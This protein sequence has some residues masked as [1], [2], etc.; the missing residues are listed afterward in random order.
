[1]AH[2]ISNVFTPSQISE[3]ASPSIGSSLQ[4]AEGSYPICSVPQLRHHIPTV[5]H[6]FLSYVEDNHDLD[7]SPLTSHMH[8]VIL[9]LATFLVE[10][11]VRD[12][13]F[14]V[15]SSE[16]HGRAL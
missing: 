14:V 11:K 13:L 1:M 4:P 2:L 9:L 6:C 10:V 7:A 16:D 3:V 12:C 5:S 15:L 8:Q